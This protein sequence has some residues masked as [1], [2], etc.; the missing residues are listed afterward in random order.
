MHRRV[1]FVCA[2]V[3]ATLAGCG[4]LEYA[5]QPVGVV[6]NVY[7]EVSEDVYLERALAGEAA[8]KPQ[9]VRVIFADGGGAER[10]RVDAEL[11]VEAG[12]V[13]RVK[14]AAD[15]TPALKLLPETNAVVGIVARPGNPIAAAPAPEPRPILP[16]YLVET[17]DLSR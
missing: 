16:R 2:A 17:I 7:V 3:A 11:H 1:S 15:H 13:V 5:A 4:S 14:L 10:A 12:D 8:G 6:E 9:W